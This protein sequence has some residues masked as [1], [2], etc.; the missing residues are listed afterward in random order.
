MQKK[1]LFAFLLP[2][3][4]L[5]SQPGEAG[6][7]PGRQ[8]VVLIVD[9]IGLGDLN[10]PDLPNFSWCLRYGAVGLM[11]TRTGAGI[12]AGLSGE[13]TYLT[14]GAARRG[15]GSPKTGEAFGANE[16]LEGGTAAE[17]YWRNTGYRP[18]PENVVLPAIAEIAALNAAED[19]SFR[20]GLL[21]A[22][23]H[24]AGFSTC[25]L[26]NA[27]TSEELGRYAVALAMD[28]R[29]LVDLGEVGS[30]LLRPDPGWP[31]GLRTDYE[32]LTAAF[33]RY[34][35]RAALLVVEL[36]DTA[37]LD[38]YSSYLSPVRAEALRHRALRAADDFLGMGRRES[39][40]TQ[41]LLIILTPTPGLP[42]QTQGYT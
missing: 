13:H 36:G 27:D 16:P 12:P 11:N 21:G 19:R 28:G 22:S 18:R 14:I 4:F 10:R 5:A 9:R 23:L 24:A 40:P 7:F 34:R 8:V 30:D 39:D 15:I 3:L 26:G 2:C 1:S 38:L 32:A 37:R 33:K 25:V 29:G 20:P 31:F 17:V 35:S 41:T 42:A 6:P